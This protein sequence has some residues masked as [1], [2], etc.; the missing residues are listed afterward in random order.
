MD[1]STNGLHDTS[2]VIKPKH[3]YTVRSLG[4]S[5]VCSSFNPVSLIT[6]FST[7]FDLPPADLQG[8]RPQPPSLI[9]TNAGRAAAMTL[10]PGGCTFMPNTSQY[11]R[12]DAAVYLVTINMKRV[13]SLNSLRRIKQPAQSLSV[14]FSV[15]EGRARQSCLPPSIKQRELRRNLTETYFLCFLT[16]LFVVKFVL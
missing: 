10:Q 14:S 5:N 13:F 8:R 7:C 2:P 9:Q 1:A 4:C 12:H 16:L 15:P 11:F 6:L 3:R